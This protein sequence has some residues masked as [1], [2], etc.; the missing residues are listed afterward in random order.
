M[1]A[2]VKLSYEFGPFRLDPSE[3]RLARHGRTVALTPKAFEVLRVLVEHAGHLVEKDTLV[4]EVWPDNFVEEGALNRNVSLIRK[5]LGE[6]AEQKYVE[7]VPKHGYRFVAAVITCDTNR[8]RTLSESEPR[9]LDG[10][11]PVWLKRSVSTFGVSSA[12]IAGT[13]MG[14]MPV[15]TVLAL[16][17]VTATALFRERNGEP[18]RR[19]LSVLHRQITF[20]GKEGA[21]TLSP[22]GK[23]IAYVS[24]ETPDRK[25]MVQELAGGSPLEIFAA[26]E[27]GHL[28]W[29][30]DG[31]ELLVW[32]RGRGRNGVYI[33]SQMGGTPRSSRL[34]CISR[35]GRP[36][37]RRLRFP[38]IWAGRSGS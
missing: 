17:A 36:T 22:D 25:V 16:V 15:A 27:V 29:S 11:V 12:Q 26:P 31:S 8:L 20:T 2:E 21:P 6:T 33:I 32:A 10:F 38:A 24:N 4:A 3:H 18:V 28:R 5:A 23:R 13:R 1:S 34:A 19:E 9:R 37:D 30:P 7:T 14:V 35:A